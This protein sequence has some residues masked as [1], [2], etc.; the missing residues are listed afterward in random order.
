[1]PIDPPGPTYTTSFER[2]RPM[3]GV[4]I[5]FVVIYGA[6]FGAYYF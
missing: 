5:G 3:F 1:M 6:M 2:M 4:V